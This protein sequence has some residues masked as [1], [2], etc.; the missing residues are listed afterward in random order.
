MD[1]LVRYYE[2]AEEI[3]QNNNLNE[4]ERLEFY[5]LHKRVHKPDEVV[6]FTH[7]FESGFIH[8]LK[9]QE[10]IRYRFSGA[11]E[12]N[13]I[14]EFLEERRK[15]LG[16]TRDLY[17]LLTYLIYKNSIETIIKL[18]AIPK[19]EELDL[20]LFKAKFNFTERRKYLLQTLEK[21]FEYYLFSYELSSVDVLIGGGFID[22]K[23]SP[24]DIDLI[25][26]ME[27][28]MFR[29]NEMFSSLNE[30]IA[31][32][33]LPEDNK[34]PLDIMR[35][36]INYDISIFLAYQQLTMIGNDVPIKIT[37]GIKDVI[38]YERP[39]YKIQYKCEI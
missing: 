18:S 26:L 37:N 11:E 30:W 4:P 29:S 27:Y 2:L 35:L 6:L 17:E 19:I 13:Y 15:A 7:L 9:Y 34:R 36:P 38:Y 8:Q 3:K 33:K 31:Q 39:V 14:V 23:G 16:L 21:F 32:Q 12:E 20:N 1:K 5:H 22:Y 24:G 10:N 25:L 28:E